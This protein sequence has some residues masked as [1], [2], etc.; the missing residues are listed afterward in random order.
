M[1]FVRIYLGDPLEISV[2]GDRHFSGES[3]EQLGPH[4]VAMQM[5]ALIDLD[6]TV[7]V[8]YWPFTIISGGWVKAEAIVH[9]FTQEQWDN[10][11]KWRDCF[12]AAEAV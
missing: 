7:P 12:L 4:S 3:R 11:Q 8:K 10:A 6:A 5:R 1:R 2:L 9:E